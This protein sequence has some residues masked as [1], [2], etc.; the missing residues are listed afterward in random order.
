MLCPVR[1]EVAIK[2]T[3]LKDKEEAEIEYKMYTYLGA[4]DNEDVE[5]YG[6]PSVYYYDTW[7]DHILLAI[8]LLDPEFSNRVRMA[9]VE[10][11]STVDTLI[12]FKECVG[13][14]FSIR[15]CRLIPV[16]LHNFS[17]IFNEGESI[18]LY[19]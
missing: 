18:A 1:R 12:I 5:R 4:I 8:T 15:I 11:L 10:K 19:S 2:F 3:P 14:R 13:L 7:N 17:D 6:I 16:S 9:R